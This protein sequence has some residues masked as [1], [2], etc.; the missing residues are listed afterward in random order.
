[1]N[2]AT[3]VKALS[4]NVGPIPED[5]TLLEA[6][7]LFP[8]PNHVGHVMP[9]FFMPEEPFHFT[10][11]ELPETEIIG[12]MEANAGLTHWMHDIHAPAHMSKEPNSGSC[13]VCKMAERM[14]ARNSKSQLGLQLLTDVHRVS[15]VNHQRAVEKLMEL[16]DKSSEYINSILVRG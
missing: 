11:L 12:R 14:L 5:A 16:V 13:E 10:T 8:K 15:F 4:D 7:L 9:A 1:M 2:M 3:L 6:P